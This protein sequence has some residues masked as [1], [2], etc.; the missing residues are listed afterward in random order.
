VLTFNSFSGLSLAPTAGV[1]ES[2]GYTIELLFRFD[3]IDGW[4]KIVDFNQGTEDCGLYFLD[5]RLDFFPIALAVGTPIDA[6]S[7]VHVV[8]TR[9]ASGTVAGYVNGARQFSFNDINELAVIDANDTLLFFRDDSTTRTEYSSGA[10]AQIELY[11]GSLSADEVTGLATELSITTP[12]P[13]EHFCPFVDG[14]TCLEAI[15]AGTY[16]TTTFQPSITYTVPDG[17]LNRE[18]LPGNFLLHLD[19]DERYR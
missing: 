19:G 6:D 3:R 15:D 10:V 16:T 17:W 18:D 9:N 4:R 8:L 1:I 2:R 12:P 13:A 5:G 14:G 11:D 7:Y